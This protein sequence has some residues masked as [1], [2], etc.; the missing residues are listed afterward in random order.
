[1]QPRSRPNP[2][3]LLNWRS[4][5]TFTLHKR[6]FA[7]VWRSG[8][9]RRSLDSGRRPAVIGEVSITSRLE[10]VP[11]WLRFRLHLRDQC[12]VCDTASWWP[13]SRPGERV[14]PMSVV[15]V[16]CHVVPTSAGS[17]PK[18]RRSGWSITWCGTGSLNAGDVGSDQQYRR[19]TR[20]TPIDPEA[21]GS[22][23]GG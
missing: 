6:G 12:G 5:R 20:W 17:R 9:I 8:R 19:S 16:L 10:E 11:R 1:M 23:A 18:D 15:L 14:G 13:G 2:E 4:Y 3:T 22:A 21:S 7:K